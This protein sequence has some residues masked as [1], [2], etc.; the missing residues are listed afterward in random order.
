MNNLCYFGLLPAK[1]THYNQNPVKSN[2]PC[3]IKL[4]LRV[5]CSKQLIFSAGETE[6]CQLVVSNLNPWMW[7]S[8]PPVSLMW[9]R[10]RRAQ[11]ENIQN[12]KLQLKTPIAV[13][14]QPNK[15][16]WAHSA[17]LRPNERTAQ[18]NISWI[19]FLLPRQHP[20]PYCPLGPG[21]GQ[22]YSQNVPRSHLGDLL[23]PH[24]NCTRSSARLMN[25]QT[26]QATALHSHP[27]LLQFIRRVC[28]PS[29][30]K[31]LTKAESLFWA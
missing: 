5:F 30:L 26:I 20:Q 19:F 3:L 31:S 12:T 23:A 25:H 11:N 18:F 29:I 28:S 21:P 24:Q 1:I 13:P 9:K 22:C 17:A 27:S 7:V 10:E 6:A 2:S 4:T 14:M 16:G 8:M 15:V